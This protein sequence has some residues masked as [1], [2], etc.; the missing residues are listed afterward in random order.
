MRGASVPFRFKSP[1]CNDFVEEEWEDSD[2]L[3]I[4]TRQMQLE[5]KVA[6]YETEL[7]KLKQV[8][9]LLDYHLIPVLT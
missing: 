4:T 8:L 1:A 5:S 2:M 3:V 6:E 7:A 9:Q